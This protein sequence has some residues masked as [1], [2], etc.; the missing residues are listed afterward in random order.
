MKICKYHHVPIIKKETKS[1][2]LRDFCGLHQ[3]FLYK[4]EVI[5]ITEQIWQIL[6]RLNKMDEYLGEIWDIAF[7]SNKYPKMQK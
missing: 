5:E 7:H 3:K 1:G 6:K 2:A 4:D